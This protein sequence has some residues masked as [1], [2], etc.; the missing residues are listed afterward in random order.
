MKVKGKPP[1]EAIEW[2]RR[3]LRLDDGTRTAPAEIRKLAETD[4]NTWYEVILREG[5]NQQIRRMFD[6]IGHSV[7][8]LRRVAIGPVRDERLAP[9]EWRFLRPD[10]IKALRAA[11]A[12]ARART[13]SRRSRGRT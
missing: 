6:A 2:L 8:K 4:A 5:K 13:L 10:E 3:G 1:E 12:P 11:K 7:V 9:G